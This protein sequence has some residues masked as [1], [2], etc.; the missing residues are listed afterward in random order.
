MKI[1]T[2]D[3]YKVVEVAFDRDLHQF[4]IVREGEVLYVINPATLEDQAQIIAD[5]NAGHDVNGWEDGNGN[6]IYLDIEPSPPTEYVNSPWLA[7]HLG[8]TKQY[9]GK[10]AKSAL[11]AGYRGSFPRPDAFVAGR[12]LWLKSRFGVDK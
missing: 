8:V 7:D 6:T 3:G 11:K 4:N 10:A 9:I 2:R 1:W 5:L 12:P